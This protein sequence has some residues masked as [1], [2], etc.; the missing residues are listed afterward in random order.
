MRL[1]VLRLS[2]RYFA[3]SLLRWKD[4]DAQRV[5]AQV[6]QP[7]AR[8]YAVKLE[9]LVQNDDRVATMVQGQ[10]DQYRCGK[11]GARYGGRMEV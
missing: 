7:Y 4:Q 3:L 11:R 10:L 8:A 6:V 9:A 2:R 5:A 1:G